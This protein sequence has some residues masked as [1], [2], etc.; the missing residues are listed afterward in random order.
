[1]TIADIAKLAGVSIGTV[2]RV[3]HNRGRVA[4]KTVEK[5]MA[6]IDEYGYQ[7]NT[8]ARNL[9]L[10]KTYTIGVV[11]PYL[12]SEYGYW[13]LIYNGVL[14]AVKELA[15]LAVSIELVEYDRLEPKTFCDAV[16]KAVESNVD[17]VLLAPLLPE[18][19]R[20]VIQRYPQVSWAFVDSPL[21]C[22]SKVITVAQNP[23]RGGFMAGRL[24]DLQVGEQGGTLVVINTHTAAFNASERARGFIEYF[25]D[26]PNFTV[27]TLDIASSAS[28]EEALELAYLDYADLCGIFIVNNA[29]ARFASHIALLGR[30]NHTT[31]IGYDLVEQNRVAMLEGK[32]DCLISQ[33]PEYQG[34]TATYQLYRK[35]ILNQKPDKDIL[36]PID[37]ILLENMQDD[38]SYTLRWNGRGE[39]R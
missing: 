15:Q 32:V 25:I 35:G 9:R 10:S 5:I 4:P 18:E 12:H 20:Q 23:F 38:T 3:L 27:I 28:A 33:R 2:D 39:A 37:I 22:Q 34:Y 19:T 16:D 11:L 31:V 17:A 30:K 8:F 29:V 24:M 14:K 26:K 13:R 6:I 1:M 21:P 36:I 7:P